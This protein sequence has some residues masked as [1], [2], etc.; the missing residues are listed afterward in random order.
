MIWYLNFFAFLGL[1]VVAMGCLDNKMAA[2]LREHGF[3][4]LDRHHL[5]VQFYN[6]NIC[7]GKSNTCKFCE[8]GTEEK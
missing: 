7:H 3:S 8:D 4:D 2:E 1:K 6:S 5:V